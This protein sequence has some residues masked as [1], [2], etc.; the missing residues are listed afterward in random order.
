M[1]TSEQLATEA[2][3]S[4]PQN[5]ADWDF[6]AL[7]TSTIETDRAQLAEA[8]SALVE[9]ARKWSDELAE[10]IIPAA[11]G[12]EAAEYQ[13]EKDRIDAAILALTESK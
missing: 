2:M 3:Q 12:E 13:A 7:I 11:D 8:L 5:P 1:K 10:Y 9:A 6:H 4:L